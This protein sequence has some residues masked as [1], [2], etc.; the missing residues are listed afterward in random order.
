M[1]SV[2]NSLGAVIGTANT[3]YQET[4][5]GLAQTVELRLRLGIATVPAPLG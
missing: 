3:T 2:L 1:A 5:R 4:E